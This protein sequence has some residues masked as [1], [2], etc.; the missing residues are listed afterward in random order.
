MSNRFALDLTV[1]VSMYYFV[2]TTPVDSSHSGV[3]TCGD[4][5][6]SCHSAGCGSSNFTV[7]GAK[8][9]FNEALEN[10]VGELTASG[11]VSGSVAAQ[12]VTTTVTTTTT[13]TPDPEASSPTS[14]SGGISTAAA[15]GIGAGVG[16]PLAIAVAS[17]LFLLFRERRQRKDYQNKLMQASMTAGGYGGHPGGE[18]YYAT[19]ATGT[20]LNAPQSGPAE[21]KDTSRYELQS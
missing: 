10:D 9:L 4:D 11:S 19:P 16:V 2:D 1:H 12:T 6:F 3:W 8:L 5:L 20:T 14:T 13:A 15:A 17:L 18:R 7:S 21:L